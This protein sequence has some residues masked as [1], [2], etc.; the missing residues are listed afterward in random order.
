M[1]NDKFKK[2]FT[3]RLKKAPKDSEPEEAETKD[4]RGPRCFEYSS[5]GHIRAYYGN[6]TQGKGR[7]TMQ[8]SGMAP[9]ED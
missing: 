4:P 9:H 8:L 2:K 6:L 7:P 5:F 3:E 1:K